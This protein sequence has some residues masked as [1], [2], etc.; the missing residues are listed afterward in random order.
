MQD[1]LLTLKKSYTKR[2]YSFL[3]NMDEAVKKGDRIAILNDGELRQ[4]GTPKEIVSKPEQIYQAEFVK[5][6]L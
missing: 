1:Q 3:L 6:K 4:C 5:K 2:S